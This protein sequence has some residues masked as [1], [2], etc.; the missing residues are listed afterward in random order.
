MENKAVR[1][2]RLKLL[3]DRYARDKKGR[4]QLAEDTGSNV[5]HL[6]QLLTGH[7]QMGD[8][9][10][11]RFEETLN[12]GLGWMDKPLDGTPEPEPSYKL[13]VAEKTLLLLFR[14]CD[15]A[16][17]EYVMEA[18]HAAAIRSRRGKP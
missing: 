18:A 6:S 1:R 4:K 13:S 9:V 2:A 11:R 7:R 5:T 8:D 16:G 12:L 14:D 3:V 15:D 17:Q 10:A